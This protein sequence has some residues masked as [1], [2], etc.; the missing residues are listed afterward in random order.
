MAATADWNFTLWNDV[1]PIKG[2][3]FEISLW[4]LV[5]VLG[6]S[7]GRLVL[8][9]SEIGNPRWPPQPNWNFTLWNDVRSIKGKQFEI[10]LW[11]LVGVLSMSRGRFNRWDWISV[12]SEIQD[13]RHGQLKFRV[14]QRRPTNKRKTV[15]DILMKLG[16]CI[17]HVKR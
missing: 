8:N 7:R 14:V 17:K 16:G 9:F 4:N 5:G 11:N 10:Y 12:K 3:P 1:R 6:M 2:K 13:G 15:W